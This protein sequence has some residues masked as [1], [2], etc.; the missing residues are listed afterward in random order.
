MPSWLRRKIR[1]DVRPDTPGGGTLRIVLQ[2]GATHPRIPALL[3]PDRVAG[4]YADRRGIGPT[5]ALAQHRA[6]LL[7]ADRHRARTERRR[8]MHDDLAGFARM[9]GY[10]KDY[11][12]RLVR[13]STGRT[14]QDLTGTLRMGIAA[15]RLLDTD[16]TVASIARTVGYD[17]R[18]GFHKRFLS[19]Y[20]LTPSEY[21]SMFRM[22]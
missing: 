14:F 22:R 15:S 12:G 9:L 11:T 17:N 2:A 13:E 20:G 3:R 10:S 19:V 8:G 7:F 16:D 5:R 4:A 21:R 18:S 6:C 1:S